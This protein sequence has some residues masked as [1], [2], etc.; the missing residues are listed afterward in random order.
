MRLNSIVPHKL[1]NHTIHQTDN[2]TKCR[3]LP[4]HFCRKC[5]RH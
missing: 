3:I 2:L 5:N 1:T 4:R